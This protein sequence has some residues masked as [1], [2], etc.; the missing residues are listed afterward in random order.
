MAE[1]RTEWCGIGSPSTHYHDLRQKTPT[2]DPILTLTK[3]TI[4]LII[5]GNSL[6]FLYNMF[7]FVYV[8]QNPLTKYLYVGFTTDLKSRLERHNQ[9]EVGSTRNHRPLTLIFLE[10]Y[11]NK[12][13]ALRRERYLKTSKGKAVLHV[14]LQK[15]FENPN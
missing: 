13:D 5:I 6:F 9:G 7:F 14:M 4:P 2:P 12:L 10:G 11:L 3:E 15:F 8:L 1:P